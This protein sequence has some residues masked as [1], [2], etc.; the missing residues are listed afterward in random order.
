LLTR[1]PL[2][3]RP[4]VSPSGGGR[5]VIAGTD[6]RVRFDRSIR[7]SLVR[8]PLTRP[9]GCYRM[10]LTK[11][12]VLGTASDLR[13]LTE[14]HCY[15]PTAPSWTSRRSPDP[16]APRR[17]RDREADG[18]QRESREPFGAQGGGGV[19]LA[20]DGQQEQAGVSAECQLCL[21]VGG[22]Q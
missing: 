22:R 1:G 19:L 7:R 8:R 2:G 15:A 6:D 12:P 11:V 5:S 9:S 3:R 13:G 20:E 14:G 18:T 21:R 17:M 4:S 16:V 10:P